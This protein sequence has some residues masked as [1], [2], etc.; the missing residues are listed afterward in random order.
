MEAS[1]AMTEHDLITL[2][3]AQIAGGALGANPDRPLDVSSVVRAAIQI[4]AEAARQLRAHHQALAQGAE[5][6]V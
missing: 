2:A 6:N 3:A 1:A 5:P 4:R